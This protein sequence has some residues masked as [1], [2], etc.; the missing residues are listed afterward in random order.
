MENDENE[1]RRGKDRKETRQTIEGKAQTESQRENQ[2]HKESRGEI[3][4]FTK[5]KKVLVEP[6]Q[7]RRNRS[8]KHHLSCGRLKFIKPSSIRVFIKQYLE[9][10]PDAGNG[11]IAKYLT[12]R[13][14]CND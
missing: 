5:K 4:V 11:T 14:G 3:K 9:P 13:K 2:S 8:D 7:K 1:Q 10:I 6:T 12:E